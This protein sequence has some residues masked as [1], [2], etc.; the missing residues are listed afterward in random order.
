MRKAIYMGILVYMI[1]QVALRHGYKNPPESAYFI[2]LD[3]IPDTSNHQK[4]IDVQNRKLRKS[5]NP[6]A[7]YLLKDRDE[8]ESQDD[9]EEQP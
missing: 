7:P 8:D 5:T 3:T 6:S 1:C 4:P 2:D 9:R